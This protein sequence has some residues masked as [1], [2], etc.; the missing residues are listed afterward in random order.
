VPGY[1]SPGSE[2]LISHGV[3]RSGLG[4]QLLPVHDATEVLSEDALDFDGERVRTCDRLIRIAH[5]IAQLLIEFHVNSSD[6][7]DIPPP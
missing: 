4:P 2:R 7:L 1:P 3:E 5:P 6:G